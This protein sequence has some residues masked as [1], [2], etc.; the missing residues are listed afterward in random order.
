MLQKYMLMLVS[1]LLVLLI[2]TAAAMTPEEARLIARVAADGNPGA[3]VL[4]AGLYGRGD[5]GYAQ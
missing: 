5:G 1:A 2:A 4:L 3:Q